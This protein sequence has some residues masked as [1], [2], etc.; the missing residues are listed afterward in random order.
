MTQVLAPL[1]GCGIV[2]YLDD[3]LVYSKTEKKHQQLLRE[4]FELLQK[5]WFYAK[6][7]KCSFMKTEIEYLEHIISK[8][9]I[10]TDS[11]KVKAVQDCTKLVSISD[12]KW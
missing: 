10:C 1:L 2:V 3:I 9:G 12:C 7:K 6:L 11:A 4:V 8:K 5:Y